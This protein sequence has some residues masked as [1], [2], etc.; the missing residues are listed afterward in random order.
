MQT[1]LIQLQK[2]VDD[3]EKLADEVSNLAERLSKGDVFQPDL[4]LKGQQWYRGARELMVQH[5]YS[6]LEDFDGCY[7]NKAFIELHI[8]MIGKTGYSSL[9]PSHPT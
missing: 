2:R 4:S 6:G 8:I 7:K 5:K 9:C 1:T 3:L